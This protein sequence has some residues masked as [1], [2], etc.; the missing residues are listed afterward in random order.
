[1]GRPLLGVLLVS[2]L[3]VVAGYG[4]APP[5]DYETAEETLSGLAKNKPI[6][7]IP[8]QF[9]RSWLL[10]RLMPGSII[11]MMEKATTQVRQE[12]RLPTWDS[13]QL[14]ATTGPAAGP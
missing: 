8:K 2:A 5:V 13:E 11:R 9:R 3:A 10:A 7:I 4:S 1:M 14:S 6:L 12:R